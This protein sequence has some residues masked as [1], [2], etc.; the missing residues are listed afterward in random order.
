MKNVAIIADT[1]A[2][3]TKRFDE[4]NRVMAWIAKDVAERKVDLVA[5][6]GDMW[7]RRSTSAERAAVGDWVRAVTEHVPLIA[8]AGNHDD[9]ADVLWLSK[10]RTKYPVYAFDR[11]GV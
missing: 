4:H 11:P 7:E 1:H 8:V 6:C 10:L 5:H 9:P 2:D 3:E